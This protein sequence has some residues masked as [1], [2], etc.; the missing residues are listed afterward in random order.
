M[1]DL[2]RSFARAAVRRDD[3][4]RFALLVAFG[5]KVYPRYRFHW[6]QIDWWDNAEFNTF[7]TKFDELP[8][9]NTQRKWTL[10]QILRWVGSVSGDTAECGVYLGSS[11]YLIC[12]ANQ[13][14]AIE[15]WHHGFDS[16]EGLSQ[17]GQHDGEHWIGGDLSAS[18]EACGRN[19]AE[20][21]RCRL[22]RGWIPERFSEVADRT[23][24]FVHVDV[25]I[26]EP[27]KASIEFFYPRLSP[28]GLIL[29]DDYGC[30]TCPG[31]TRAIDEFL[32]DK[33]EKMIALPDGG[34]VLIRGVRV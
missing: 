32:S 4:S 10:W 7:L 1:L 33:P 9:Y 24:S 20:F 18:L 16:F 29:C 28:G 26:F 8:G 13:R 2:L 6:P 31:A 30:T 25:D 17:P 11:S 27:T 12:R 15:K 19:L 3:A 34:G 23:F 14:S 21:Q 5:R 22:Y